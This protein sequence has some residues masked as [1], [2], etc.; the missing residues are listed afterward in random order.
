MTLVTVHPLLL[1]RMKVPFLKKART[2]ET[3]LQRDE[4]RRL[5]LDA[6]FEPCIREEIAG[7]DSPKS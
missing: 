5:R 2:E 6:D 1:A 7:W 3:R 4:L